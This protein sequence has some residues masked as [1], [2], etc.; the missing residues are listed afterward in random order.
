[1]R[2][3]TGLHGLQHF[4]RIDPAAPILCDWLHTDVLSP[5]PRAVDPVNLYLLD[6]DD[7]DLAMWHLARRQYDEWVAAGFPSE[8]FAFHRRHV[9][10]DRCAALSPHDPRAVSCWVRFLPVR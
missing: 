5:S 8:V 1:M 4:L 6:D 2:A 9:H 10:L 3:S 7:L